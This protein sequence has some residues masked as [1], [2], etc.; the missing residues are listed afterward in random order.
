MRDSA[1]KSMFRERGFVKIRRKDKNGQEIDFA[2]AEEIA[3]EAGAE[4][5][6][7]DE[8]N[9]EVWH[10]DVELTEMYKVKHAV[11]KNFPDVEIEDCDISYEPINPIQ[12]SDEDME[13]ASSVFEALNEIEDVTKVYAN[14]Q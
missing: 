1:V 8:D 4:E 13:K 14:I 9:A 10:F 2:K 7:E 11:E 3:I 6:R 5:V 12:L